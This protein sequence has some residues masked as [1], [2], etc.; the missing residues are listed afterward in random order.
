[1]KSSLKTHMLSILA[2]GVFCIL[3]AGSMED[4]SP[5]KSSHVVESHEPDP[6]GME[7]SCTETYADTHNISNENI[8][9]F[10]FW[11]PNGFRKLFTFNGTSLSKSFDLSSV[12][13]HDANDK[14][15]WYFFTEG[16]RDSEISALHPTYTGV[17]RQYELETRGDHEIYY[18]DKAVSVKYQ[19]AHGITTQLA[20]GSLFES[21]HAIQSNCRQMTPQDAQQVFVQYKAAINSMN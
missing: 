15:Q 14:S 10:F 20:D 3:A 11:S 1:M 16:Q 5:N 21:G 6:K 7:L 17:D 13:I 2:L 18:D 8:H 9:D 19:Y 4:S 12:N